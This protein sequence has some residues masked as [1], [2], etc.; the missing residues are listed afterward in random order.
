[1]DLNGHEA[2]NGG[3]SQRKPTAH[4]A[5]STRKS[6]WVCVFMGLRREQPERA[7]RL[8]QDG[9]TESKPSFPFYPRG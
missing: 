6:L 2:G 5:S 4:L 8:P 7:E 1:V 9:L 3:Y